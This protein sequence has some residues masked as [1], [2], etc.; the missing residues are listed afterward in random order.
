[1]IDSASSKA[2]HTALVREWMLR[3]FAIES[4]VLLLRQREEYPAKQPSSRAL[5][6][7]KRERAGEMARLNRSRDVQINSERGGLITLKK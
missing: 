3:L 1:M 6:F 2:A 4:F 5:I 7:D